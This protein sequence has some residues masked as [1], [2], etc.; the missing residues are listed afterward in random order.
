MHLRDSQETKREFPWDREEITEAT[1][2]FRS[3]GKVSGE[4]DEYWGE[5]NV[6]RKL[7]K[8]QRTIPEALM[9]KEVMR[10]KSQE[11]DMTSNVLRQSTRTYRQRVWDRRKLLEGKTGGRDKYPEAKEKIPKTW[12][13]IFGSRGNRQDTRRTTKESWKKGRVKTLDSRSGGRIQELLKAAKLIKTTEA[14]TKFRMQMKIWER[15][16]NSKSKF[17]GEMKDSRSKGLIKEA[18]KM[19]KPAKT[20]KKQINKKVL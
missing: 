19:A 3:N 17:Q 7:Q 18:K 20:D 13:K 15:K 10:K 9:V 14:K 12:D 5:G 11:R 16:R 2:E 1:I 8:D 4:Q 6:P